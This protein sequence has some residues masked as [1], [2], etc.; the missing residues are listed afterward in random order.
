VE[1][2]W[3][4]YYPRLRAYEGGNDDD[5]RDPG[6]R[7]SRGI[8]QSEWNV[9]RRQHPGQNLPADVWLAPESAITDI[10]HN[11]QYWS[12][13][14]CP[15]LPAGPDAAVADYGVNSGVG[16]SGRVLR[17]ICGL[18]TSTY[19]IN[20]EVVA[21]VAKRD[22]KAVADA[23]N[24][25][26]IAFLRGLSTFRTFGTGWTRRWRDM[27]TFCDALATAA[28][29]AAPPLPTSP[30][31]TPIGGNKAQHPPPKAVTTG[32]VAGGTAAAASMGTFAGWIH[33]HPFLTTI[34]VCSILAA[35]TWAVWWIWKRYHTQAFQ[36]TPGTP[37]VPEKA[38]GST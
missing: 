32:T 29:I 15:E 3:P 20:D 35:T 17:H 4:Q 31:A 5:P 27:T 8:I 30:G 13:Q 34:V 16:R 28:K 24:A 7:T 38:P 23:I 33:A 36:P 12:G 9:Y 14:R 22:A 10:Y 26:R 18:P 19:V 1:S 11:G 2:T 25:E 21:A 37:V 6:G